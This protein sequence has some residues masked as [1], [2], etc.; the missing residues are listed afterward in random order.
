MAT[1]H[2]SDSQK[3][4]TLFGAKSNGDNNKYKTATNNVII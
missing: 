2:K 1:G 3:G 4:D